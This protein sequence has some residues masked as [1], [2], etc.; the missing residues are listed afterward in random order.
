M[1]VPQNSIPMV[2]LDGPRGYIT[3]GGMVTTLKVRE[4]ISTYEDPGWYTNPPGTEAR[5]ASA[6]ELRRNGIEADR[7]TPA[8]PPAHEGH[9]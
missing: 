2:G 3:L 4:G 1:P 5:R 9:G 6:Q 7:E 8:D